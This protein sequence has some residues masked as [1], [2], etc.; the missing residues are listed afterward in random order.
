MANALRALV[1]PRRSGLGDASGD[2]GD[3]GPVRETLDMRLLLM[4]ARSLCEIPVSQ[5]HQDFP[6]APS[7]LAPD[8][9]VVV[10]D[11]GV[12]VAARTVEASGYGLGEPAL[13]AVGSLVGGLWLLAAVT[14]A[15]LS[16][17]AVDQERAWTAGTDDRSERRPRG[18]P[19]RHEREGE[20]RGSE[21]GSARSTGT[22]TLPQ[23][24]SSAFGT[25]WHAVSA[26]P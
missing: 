24:A 16:G 23:R 22:L 6:F 7:L 15:D 5:L 10:S 2:H 21:T 11:Y 1:Y 19:A 20:A 25:R 13:E 14:V 18:V 12:Y 3:R 4:A 8:H 9:K 26:T 17:R